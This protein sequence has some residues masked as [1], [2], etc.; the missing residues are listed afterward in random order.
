MRAMYALWLREVKRY[1]RSKQRIALALVQPVL[2]LL[3]LGFGLRPVYQRAGNGD[4]LQFLAPGVIGMSVLF[5]SVNSGV[6]LL[7]DR[8]F[9]FL[10]ETLVS[11]VPRFQIMLG[12]TLGAA[13]V[14]VTQ[15]VLVAA[16]CLAAGFRPFATSTATGALLFVILIAITFAALGTA[17]GATMRDM[18]SYQGVLNLLVL[19]LSLLSGV[20][21]PLEHLPIVLATLTE[22]DPLSYGIDGIRATLIGQ[23]HY[24]MLLD[25]AVL[26]G[27]ATIF[28]GVATWRFAKIEP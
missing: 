19:P 18:T 13:S 23:G 21:F 14:A 6:A 9:G 7:F 22:M 2:N 11:P 10:K 26:T 20:L 28:M 16:I 3:V 27:S 1:W 5:T 25:A 24:S 15:G 12:R 8:Q 4:F 17:I